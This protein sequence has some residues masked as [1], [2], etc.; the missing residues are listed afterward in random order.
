MALRLR[1]GTDAER[2]LITP[3]QGE[4]I[5]TIDT[6]QLYAGDGTTAGGTLVSADAATTLESLTDTDLAG[7]TNGQV[8]S[9]NS[10]SGNWEPKTLVS[11][12]ADG[13]VEGSNYQI[14]I[15]SDDSTILV[16]SDTN[17]FTGSLTGNV[18]G[19]V[20]GDVLGNLTGD[21]LGNVTGNAAGAHTGTLLGDVTGN[22][23]GDVLGNV[24]GNLSGNA[25]GDH[26]GTFTGIITATGSFDGDITGS[27]F[28]DDSSLLVDGVG[29]V[30]TGD[31]NNNITT[32]A[33]LTTATLELSGT[34]AGNKAGIQIR[35]DGNAEDTYSLF[36]IVGATDSDV[37]SA[38]NFSKSRGT[39]ASPTAVQD[40]D[41]ILGINYFGYD[42]DNSPAI[43]AYIGVRVDG[44]PSSGVVPGSIGFLTTDSTGSINLALNITSDS[45]T[46]FGGAAQLVAY[47]D[48]SAR[49]AAIPTPAA[50]MMIYLTATNKA[51]VYNGSG[52]IDLH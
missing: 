5:Y 22:V 45:V 44:T 31:V 43:A 35:T 9:W 34:G 1:R 32:T 36:D 52:W 3:L 38:I 13:V 24:T 21:V 12:I 20:T 51:Q 33:V 28:G 2:L 30:I 29:S 27:I 42:S 47:A 23:T 50:G 10:S 11:N 25:F 4:L 6:K 19:N 15:V 14:N 41:E 46:T 7:K 40:G 48:T 18:T 8:L 37:G 39:L 16:N 49:N 17:E 26:Q